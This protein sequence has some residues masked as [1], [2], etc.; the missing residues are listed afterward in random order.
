MSAVFSLKNLFGKKPSD[1]ADP[2]VTQELSLGSRDSITATIEAGSTQNDTTLDDVSIKNTRCAG[3]DAAPD[4]GH[5]AR[6][7]LSRSILTQDNTAYVAGPGHRPAGFV[8]VFRDL[9][10]RREAQ[11]AVQKSEA[12]LRLAL[13]AARMGIWTLHLRS[14]TQTRDENLNRLLGLA[15]EATTQPFDE[16][17]DHLHPDD[18]GRVRAAFREAV[19]AGRMLSAE[20]RVVRPDGTTLH[21]GPRT[22]GRIV[23]YRVGPDG[24]RLGTRMPVPQQPP[25]PAPHEP[26]SPEVIPAEATLP[27]AIPPGEPQPEPA[28]PGMAPAGPATESLRDLIVR[29]LA[30]LPVAKQVSPMPAPGRQQ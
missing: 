12:R 24:Y 26:T 9:T 23:L 1:E 18:R 27:R 29:A 6:V 20:F 8:K 19:A 4:T 21:A 25:K 30:G 11:E 16:F 10:E 2:S 22:G 17:F 7:A 28:P 5:L 14:D 13:A 3:I 15:P